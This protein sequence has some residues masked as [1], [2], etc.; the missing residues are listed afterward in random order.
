M[1]R[2]SSRQADV[3]V[4]TRIDIAVTNSSCEATVFYDDAGEASARIYALA[5]PTIDGRLLTVDELADCRLDCRVEGPKCR[6]STTL[7][8]RV[9]L[10]HRGVTNWGEIPALVA[11]AYLPDPCPW[12][13]ELPFLYRVIGEVRL[14]ETVIAEIDQ[15][16]G[17]RPMSVVRNRVKFQG[18]TWVPRIVRQ[19]HVL[20]EA[21]LVQWRETSTVLA[22]VDPHDDDCKAA[23]EV[24]VLLLAD[25]RMRGEQLLTRMRQLSRFPSVAMIETQEWVLETERSS[26][27]N[28]LTVAEI[29]HLQNSQSKP[30]VYIWPNENGDFDIASETTRKHAVIAS[31][32][33]DN[34]TSLMEA[35]SA[36]DALQRDLAGVYD[37][38]G[39]M[40]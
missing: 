22:V 18:K 14:G 5:A 37:P 8:T 13:P 11:E 26:A 31:R 23:D 30:D 21:P 29:Q 16:F 10:T 7:P 35:R 27:R 34:A 38:A 40:A 28:T 9:K 15:S 3:N 12:S 19:E 2:A 20:G 25:L 36:C 33:V 24:G 17:I 4:N 32:D 6:Y 39:Y 1:G